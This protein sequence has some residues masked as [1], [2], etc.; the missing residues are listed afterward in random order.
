MPNKL[1]IFKPKGKL[2][3]KNF[4]SKGLLRGMGSQCTPSSQPLYQALFILWCI[5]TEYLWKTIVTQNTWDL[6][7]H[8]RF[9]KVDDNHS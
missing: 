5:E 4:M 7:H 6:C 3:Q 2:Y 9:C 1:F 8:E